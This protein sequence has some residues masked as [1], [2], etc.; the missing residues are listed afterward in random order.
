MDQNL[1]KNP[2]PILV[3]G[4]GNEFRRDDNAGHLVARMVED[5]ELPGVSVIE[6]TGE[7]SELMRLWQ[8]A[9]SVIVVDAFTGGIPGS[10]RRI[11]AVHEP[12]PVALFRSSSHQFGLPHAIELS[13]SLRELPPNLLVYGIGGQN[14]DSGTDITPEVERSLSYAVSMLVQDIKSLQARPQTELDE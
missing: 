14:F 12:L 13:R 10:I 2:H 6:S 8:N 9:E 4:I 3:I 5:L 1:L 7:G 11:D